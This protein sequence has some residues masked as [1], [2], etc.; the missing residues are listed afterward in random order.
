MA[1]II[2]DFGSGNTSKNDWDYAKRMVDEMAD[3]DSKKHEIIIKWQLFKRAGNNIPLDIELFNMIYFY[4]ERK[5][6]RTTAS[7]FDIASLDR[8]K[9]YDVPF[10][11][12]ANNRNLDYL[13]GE[14]PRKIPVY[15]SCNTIFNASELKDNNV[16]VLYCDSNYPSSFFKYVAYKNFHW[17]GISDHTS[18]WEVYQKMNP[19]IYECHY[20]LDDSTGLD[21]GDFARTPKQLEEIL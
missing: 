16:K 8:L 3:I 17:D 11:K 19:E 10:I 13:I 21:A 2:L 18:D 5:G 6:Y 14:I 15:V 4:A 12:I 20:K 9:M 1:Q 7:V